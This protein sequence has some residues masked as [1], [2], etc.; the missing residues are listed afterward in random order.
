MFLFYFFIFIEKELIISNTLEKERSMSKFWKPGTEKPRFVED[1]EGGVLFYSAAASSSSS[2]C[3]IIFFFS[4]S[5]PFPS[6]V[7]LLFN[8]A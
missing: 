7:V 3:L 6:F 5:S 8:C 2:G 1:E 4:F